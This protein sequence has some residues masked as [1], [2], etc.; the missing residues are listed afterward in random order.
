VFESTKPRPAFKVWLE[1]EEGYVFGPGVYSIL[2]KVD[3]TGTL[4]EAA[5]SLGMS[6]KFAWGLV[7]KGEETLGQPLISSHKGGRA[8]GGGADRCRS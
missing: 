6:H 4:K 7:R 1:T 8:G 2:R 3:E 5:K